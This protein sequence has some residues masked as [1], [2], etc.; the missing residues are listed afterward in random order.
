MCTGANP[1]QRYTCWLLPESRSCREVYC[2]GRRQRRNRG[3]APAGMLSV[4]VSHK[5]KDF[6]AD[7]VVESLEQLEPDA[8]E[9]LLR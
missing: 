3:G 8:F 6:H 4:G 2:R 5:G 1:I 7:V 9:R